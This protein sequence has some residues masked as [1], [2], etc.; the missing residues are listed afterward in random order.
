[1]LAVANEPLHGY[2]IMQKV[3]ED[4]NDSVQL[5]PGTLYGALKRLLEDGWLKEVAN[6]SSTRRSYILA[7]QGRNSLQTELNNMQG[8]INLSRQLNSLV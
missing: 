2:A 7:T 4:S 3:K 1:M 6:D 5:G 8:I